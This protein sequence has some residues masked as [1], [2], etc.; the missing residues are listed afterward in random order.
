MLFHPIP[1]ENLGW[2]G[3]QLEDLQF[4]SVKIAD[5]AQ[6]AESR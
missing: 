5:Q 1:I 6:P 2:R 4:A 3:A